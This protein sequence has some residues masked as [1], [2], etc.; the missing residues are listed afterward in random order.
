MAVYTIDTTRH[1]YETWE[2]DAA[3]VE[4]AERI[5]RSSGTIVGTEEGTDLT[6]ED[7]RGA[8]DD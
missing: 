3:S 6:I 7:V 2:V 5:F 1:V 4:E 8:C